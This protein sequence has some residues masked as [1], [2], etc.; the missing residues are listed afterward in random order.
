MAGAAAQNS[1]YQQNREA[2]NAEEK[3][4]SVSDAC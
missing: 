2:G 4:D 3:A 1:E